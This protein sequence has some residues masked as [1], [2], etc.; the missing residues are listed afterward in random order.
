L[1][2]KIVSSILQLSQLPQLWLLTR[3]GR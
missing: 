2:S 1:P 3:I